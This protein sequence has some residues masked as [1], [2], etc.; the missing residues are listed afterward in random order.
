[1][2]I[3]FS[4][5]LMQRMGFHVF[6]EAEAISAS[7]SSVTVYEAR[8]IALTTDTTEVSVGTVAGVDYRLAAG[9][10]VNATCNAL[11]ADVF[12]D[13][14]EEW[15]KEAKCQ[16]P[17]VLVQLGPT[18]EHNCGAGRVRKEQDGSFTTF[19]CFPNARTELSELESRAL[20]PIVSGLT[21]VLNEENR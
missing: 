20:A 21:C 6:A 15:K 5:E 4:N 9:S 2:T 18:Q 17:F 7:F 12:A 14:E 16:G 11:V 8:G 10:S 1:M 13:N 19:D 3:T